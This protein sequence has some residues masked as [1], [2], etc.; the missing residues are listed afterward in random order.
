MGWGR[1]KQEE[2]R[3]RRGRKKPAAKEEGREKSAGCDGCDREA[4]PI[5]SA[6]VSELRKGTQTQV[7]T[8]EA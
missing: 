5:S 2:E 1:G 3:G 8:H 6:G 4:L 7:D